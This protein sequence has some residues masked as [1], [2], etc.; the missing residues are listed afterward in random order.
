MN[1]K[2]KN[3]IV[4]AR[5]NEDLEW[6]RT[7]ALGYRVVI[8]N[9]GK[10][11]AYDFPCEVIHLDN[12]GRESHTYLTHLI[13][14]Y[15]HLSDVT[16]FLQGRIDDLEGWVHENPENYLQQ[17]LQYGFS[18]ARYFFMT[19]RNWLKVDFESDPLYAEAYK[20]GSLQKSQNVFLTYAC[21]FLGPLPTITLTSYKGCFAVSRK[22]VIRRPR[23]FYE[24]MRE[25]VSHHA[26]PEEGHWLE[27]MW[28]YLFGGN[29]YLLSALAIPAEFQHLFSTR[30]DSHV[31]IG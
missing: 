11:V 15:D 13:K 23:S 24:S 5:Y 4:I 30:P 26:N 25:T 21:Q 9:K 10:R 17:A 18:A 31:D 7:Y 6:L 20:T 3:T 28:A 2:S 16:I 8:Y 1:Q 12:I 29:S 27:R 22:A 19:P 14:E